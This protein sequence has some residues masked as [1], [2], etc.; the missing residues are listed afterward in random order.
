MLGNGGV[1]QV[2]HDISRRLVKRSVSVRVCYFED[3]DDLVPALRNDDVPVTRISCGSDVVRRLLR[4]VEQVSPDI[5]HMHMI[6]ANVVGRIVGRWHGIPVVSTEHTTYPNRPLVARLADRITS[7]LADSIVAVSNSVRSPLPIEFGGREGFINTLGLQDES[8]F[9]H[10]LTTLNLS[11]KEKVISIASGRVQR[12][13]HSLSA[14][15]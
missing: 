10:Q 5:I 8:W 3:P 11:E 15:L 7:P 4:L 2:T 12:W 14:H 9:R 13:I 6:T 1:P